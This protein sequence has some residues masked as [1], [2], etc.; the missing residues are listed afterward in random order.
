MDSFVTFYIGTYFLLLQF[1]KYTA[2][3]YNLMCFSVQN[4]EETGLELFNKLENY[5]K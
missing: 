3:L 1:P 5:H 4:F 2:E